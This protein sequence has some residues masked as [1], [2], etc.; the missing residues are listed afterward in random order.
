VAIIGITFAFYNALQSAPYK[1]SKEW[2][3]DSYQ[4]GALPKNFSYVQ[5][6][7]EQGLWIIKSDL[8]APSKPNVIAKLPSN[9]TGSTFHIQLMPDGI[10]KA[11]YQASVD[12]KIISGGQAQAAGLVVRFEDK[13]Q[14]FVLL[15]DSMNNIFSLCKAEPGQLLCYA[16]KK[17]VIPSGQWHT[18]MAIV[19]EEGIGGYLDGKLL[20]KLNN[21]HYLQGQIGVLTKE[22]TEAYF[23]D[24]KMKY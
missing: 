8:S 3:F 13:E 6:D 20:L 14:Y 11:N 19:S 1:S 23:D 2:Y 16:E 9:D 15:A 17:V 21:S 10:V 4:A 5:T 22:D 24:L 12:F 7:T 18:I